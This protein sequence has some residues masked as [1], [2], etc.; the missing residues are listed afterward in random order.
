MAQ[1][2]ALMPAKCAAED[3]PRTTDIDNRAIDGYSL[4]FDR[5]IW[6]FKQTVNNPRPE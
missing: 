4:R 6:H 1:K 2:S 3:S 5:R